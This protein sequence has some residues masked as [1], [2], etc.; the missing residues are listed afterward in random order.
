MRD[1]G[2]DLVSRKND[3][4]NRRNK[5]FDELDHLSSTDEM[6]RRIEL[7]QQAL[8]MTSPKDEPKLWAK[9]Q[10]DL[11]CSLLETPMGPQAENI[12]QAI[13]HFKQ[14][15]EVWSRLSLE[16]DWAVTQNNL[17][18]AYRERIHGK[19]GENIERAIDLFKQ[20]LETRIH[21]S[22]PEFWAL[23]QLNLAGTY[24][25]HVRGERAGNLELAIE[26]AN[27]ALEVYTRVSHP[28]EWAQ[29]QNILG[30]IHRVRIRESRRKN[31]EQAIQHF[32]QALEVHQ[33]QGF[34]EDWAMIQQNLGAAYITRLEGEHAENAEKSIDHSQQALKVYDEKSF[35]MDWA[36]LQHNLGN[37]YRERIRGDRAEN[38]EQAIRHFRKALVVRTRL[39]LSEDQART[40]NSL[41]NAYLARLGDPRGENVKQAI[42]CHQQALKVY[43]RQAFP[44]DWARTCNDL[45]NA[46]LA[47]LREDQIED[48]KRMENISQAISYYQMALE[49]R[50]REDLPEDW[51]ETTSNLAGAE[52]LR[53]TEEDL[54]QAILNLQHALEIYTEE[55][56]PNLWARTHNNLAIIHTERSK[57]Y[58]HGENIAKAI[59]HY[60]EALRVYTPQTFPILCLK[61]SRP[62]GNLAF[63][64]KNWELV[65]DAYS[66]VLAAQG[67]LMQAAFSSESEKAE[68]VEAQN[69]PPRLALAHVKLGNL[70]K[71]VEV[72]EKGHAQLLRESFELQ[73]QN[74]E[75]LP[76]LGFKDL[77]D[78]YMEARR[79]Y[80][81][82][83]NRVAKQN[84]DPADWEL[85]FEKL[86]A[87]IGAIRETAGGKYREYRYF[88]Q[89]LPIEEIQKQAHERPIVY[90]CSTTGGGFALVVSKRDVEVIEL[91]DLEQQALQDQI[92]RPSNEQIKQINSHIQQGMITSE[93]IQAVR[94]GFFSTYALWNLT[95]HL[96]KTPSQLILQ[97][98]TTW[99]ETI[100]ETTHWLWDGFMG[101]VIHGLKNHGTAAVLIPVGQ[102]ALLPLHAA[103][104]QDSPEHARRYAL[105]ELSLSYVPSAHSLQQAALAAQRPADRLLLVD[106][107]DGSLKFAKDEVQVAMDGFEQITHLSGKSATLAMV[108]AGMEKAHVLHFATH[109]RAGW[110]KAEQAQ[111]L[112]SDGAL[113]LPDIFKLDLHQ[114]RLAVLSACETGIPGLE[115]IDEMIGLPA[116]MLQAGVP[117][118]IGSLWSVDDAST[119]MLMARF[120]YLWCEIELSPQ[121][122]LRQAQT[123]LRD[124]TTKQ[125]KGWLDQLI[126]GEITGM[127]PNTAQ[128]FYEYIAWKAPEA[129]TFTS[130]F[131]WAAFTYTG[132]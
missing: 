43:T 95:P 100:D 42:E 39:D 66:T 125:I 114:A 67:A 45:G 82:L 34:P 128:A 33:K 60:Q 63:D 22:D 70:Q 115:L 55:T 48:T 83:Q 122:A 69:L 38:M 84:Y 120:Y 73:Q 4:Q 109:G 77:Y 54:E 46:Y 16:E 121:E 29:T 98:F 19:R 50:T 131:F 56:Y 3:N 132:I 31:I 1:L 30:E 87:T 49:V 126:D 103:W 37:A 40:L 36:T 12:E 119:A 116:G 32:H 91:P 64:D 68:I 92:W 72:L 89:S 94:G 28:H 51:A 8:K 86:R 81:G 97:L 25:R 74:L 102:L 18:T 62:L 112:L 104:T 27:R 44:E 7:C 15:L 96:T 24:Y 23:I 79:E 78:A 99:L 21:E 26:Y 17:A 65:Q 127:S 124:S 129:R 52:R 9:L 35:P 80:H 113:A 11:G 5:I 41:G 88:H 53:G 75:R 90:L 6:S 110:E 20:I 58:H 93:D 105:D 111:L 130:P 76:D 2:E 117:G 61:S 118:V 71:A 107:P 14:A 108:K 47:R 13:L 123:W 85:A 106:N 57:Q 10:D 59:E 101:K